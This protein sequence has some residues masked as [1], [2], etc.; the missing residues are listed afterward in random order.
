MVLPVEERLKIYSIIQMTSAS[1]S[2]LA[3]LT[4][5]FMIFRSHKKL[6]TPLHRLLLGLSISDFIASFA[7]SFASTLSPKDH[8]GWNASG[9]MT[10]CR[11]Q[12]FIYAWGQN[13]S[14]LYNCSLCIYYLIEIKYTSLRERLAKIEIFLHVIPVLL[15]L[16]AAI[17]ILSV[18]EFEPSSASCAM[19][20]AS[21]IECQF[22]S[23][24]ECEGGWVEEH[25]VLAMIWTCK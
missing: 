4:I 9:N 10:L 5:M 23:E 15:P 24:V 7:L 1:I 13:A 2:M 6:S 3:S 18:D 8:I 22:D 20:A 19:N 25:R 11:T 17:L 21:P 12:G 16:I 14:P